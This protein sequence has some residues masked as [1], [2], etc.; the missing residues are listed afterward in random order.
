MRSEISCG[1]STPKH[2]R[3]QTIHCKQTLQVIRYSSHGS[4]FTQKCPI[5]RSRLTS[6][7]TQGEQKDSRHMQ[8]LS[9]GGSISG[10]GQQQND[11]PQQAYFVLVTSRI[12]SLCL[13]A[14]QHT[15]KHDVQHPAGLLQGA[16]ISLNCQSTSCSPSA[17]IF[18]CVSCID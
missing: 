10:Q 17:A 15:Q 4:N 5:I 7:A 3:R 9:I 11:P 14:T 18:S 16:S 12:L 6:P 8:I 1:T 13:Y 2:S